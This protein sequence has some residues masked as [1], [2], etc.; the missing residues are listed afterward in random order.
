MTAATWTVPDPGGS[1]DQFVRAYVEAWNS[2]DPDRLL[3]FLHEEVEYDDSTWPQTMHGHADVREFLTAAW[4]AF[5]DMRFDVV[6]GPYRLGDNKAAIWWR[7]SGT[8]LGPLEPPGYAPTGRPWELDGVDF[9]EYRDGRI[10]R[11]VILFDMAN[12]ARQV[13]L[14]PTAE[15]RLGRLAVLMQRWTCRLRPK[16]PSRGREGADGANTVTATG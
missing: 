5:P 9:H 1:I 15:S 13:G 3:A 6:E 16:R 10:V 4:R 14:I 12:G 7:G 11:L 2:H 8:M